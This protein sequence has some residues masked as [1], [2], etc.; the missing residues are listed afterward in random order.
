VRLQQSV[1]TRTL[2]ISGVGIIHIILLQRALLCGNVANPL[3]QPII[4]YNIL[5]CIIIV[6]SPN[7]AAVI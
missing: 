6:K 3:K 1:H 2:Y 7:T 4:L 5:Y